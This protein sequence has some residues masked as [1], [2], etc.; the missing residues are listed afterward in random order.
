VA[1]K[2]RFWNQNYLFTG[3]T[4]TPSSEA[5]G[6]PVEALQDQQRTYPWRTATGWTITDHNNRIDFNRGGVKV[7]T[8][9]NGTYST[10]ASLATAITA[11]LEA[12]DATPVWATDY[13]VTSA[14]KFTVNAGTTYSML[15]QSGANAY[16]SIG[17]SLGFVVTSDDTG[18]TQYTADGVSYQS[19][20]H[21]V[22]TLTT[23]QVNT[24]I[25]SA[26][27]IARN[28]STACVINL[29]SSPTNVWTA[30][31]TQATFG[32]VGP[33][34][35]RKYFTSTDQ[36]YR[37]S[38]DDVSNTTGYFQIGILYITAYLQMDYCFSDNMS[39]H[40]ADFSNIN[41]SIG[42]AHFTNYRSRQKRRSLEA[43][44]IPDVSAASYRTFFLNT[45]IGQNFFIDL[46]PDSAAGL[47]ILGE[48]F[49][50]YL[51]EPEVETY[52]PFDLFTFNFSIVEA[53]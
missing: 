23:D 20:H 6:F 53:L 33:L 41:V 37:L 45:N 50:C 47:G 17:R 43:S 13:N 49:Y 1:T 15:W 52:V 24:G 9:A 36:Y 51:P 21:L 27:V 26:A 18:L 40:P 25:N 34:D 44:E 7:A 38:V 22:V 11:A 2:P 31:T 32:G 39:D 35:A 28:C 8:V 14:N 16:R 5:V 48:F 46:E 19:T 3:A 4:L 10:G 12:A 30:P 29:Q 42:G